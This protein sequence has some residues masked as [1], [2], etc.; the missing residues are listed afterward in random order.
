MPPNGIVI[1]VLHTLD[2]NFQGQK[3]DMLICRKRWK[4]MQK[5]VHF[6]ICD[7]M[8]PLQAD[9]LLYYFD[10]NFHCQTFLLCFFNKNCARRCM[11][12]ADC[13]DSHDRMPWKCFCLRYLRPKFLSMIFW[14]VFVFK[15]GFIVIWCWWVFTFDVFHRIH[16]TSSSW[17]VMNSWKKCLVGFQLQIGM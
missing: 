13:V 17:S 14:M 4:L 8:A 12:R 2:L 11:F 9:V 3:F 5:C 7:Q 1:V 15:I 6:D 10:L 16:A